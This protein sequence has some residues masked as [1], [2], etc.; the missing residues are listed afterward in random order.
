MTTAVQTIQD[1]QPSKI[2]KEL[3]HGISLIETDLRSS[4]KEANRN[5]CNFLLGFSACMFAVAVV[6]VIHTG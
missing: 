1:D 3:V 2:K 6:V 4:W 5:K